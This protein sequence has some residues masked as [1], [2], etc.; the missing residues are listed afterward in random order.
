MLCIAAPT[1]APRGLT[2]ATDPPH[3]VN[4]SWRE[5]AVPNGIVQYYIV[6][7]MLADGS[8][9][10]I[11]FN[12]VTGLIQVISNLQESTNYNVTVQAYTIGVGP[13]ASIVVG[14]HA[15]SKLLFN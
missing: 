12:H 4:V 6:Q 8:G 9:T 13:A 3:T 7:Y 2:F 11:S 15:I 5:P 1:T 14:A 10:K